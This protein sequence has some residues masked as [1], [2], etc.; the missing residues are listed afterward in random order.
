MRTHRRALFCF[1]TALS[2][3]LAACGGS[4][5]VAEPGMDAMTDGMD[6]MTGMDDHDDD[7][8][9][10]AFGEPADVSEAD[11]TI[12]IEGNNELQWEPITVDVAAGETIAFEV[13][14][15]GT[16]RHDF[17][18]G[19]EEAQEEHEA[20]MA[21]MAGEMM[22]DDPNAITIEPDATGTL[23][24]MFTEPGTVLYGCHEPGHYDAGMVGTITVSEA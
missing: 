6:A 14:N 21:Q 20:E 5:P 15:V 9:T 13:V 16:V 12:R 4:E 18:L 17:F 1:I 2:L 3:V 11:R 8:H 22:H 23:A 10:F 19:P 24:W 7:G